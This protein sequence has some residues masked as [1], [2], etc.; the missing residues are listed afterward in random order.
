MLL[1]E[2]HLVFKRHQVAVTSISA[3]VMRIKSSELDVMTLLRR[4]KKGRTFPSYTGIDF[5]AVKDYG[6]IYRDI[7]YTEIL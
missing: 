7:E 3:D 4:L 2:L 5:C 1:T 6:T